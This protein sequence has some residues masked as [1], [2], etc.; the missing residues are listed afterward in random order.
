[1]QPDDHT[2]QRQQAR[3]LAEAVLIAPEPHT[4]D[5]PGA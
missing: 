3:L 4:D 2:A 5:E 1:M